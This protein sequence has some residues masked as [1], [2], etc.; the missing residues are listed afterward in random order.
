MLPNT[1]Q[2][3][4]Q[5]P[6]Q[7]IIW[8]K[9][10]LV[11]R[12]RNPGIKRSILR[13]GNGEQRL[14]NSSFPHGPCGPSAAPPGFSPQ[15]Q[16]YFHHSGL[17][18]CLKPGGLWGRRKRPGSSKFGGFLWILYSKYLSSFFCH[19]FQNVGFG[20][21]HRQLQL[22]ALPL[23]RRETLGKSLTSPF[24]PLTCKMGQ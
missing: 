16:D 18:S 17:A 2:C 22:S 19:C 7:R 5:P 24:S 4:R 12:L 13:A 1:L 21:R 15:H 3:T 8:P 20:M 14:G 23:S 9:M 10:S 6:W 11:P